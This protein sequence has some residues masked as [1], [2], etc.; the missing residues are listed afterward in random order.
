MLRPAWYKN[1]ILNKL[2]IIAKLNLFI[3][4]LN[5]YIIYKSLSIVFRLHLF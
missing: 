2:C 3:A 5:L 4:K 1:N